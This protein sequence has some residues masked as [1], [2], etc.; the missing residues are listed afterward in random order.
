MTSMFSALGPTKMIPSCFNL[1]SE[2]QR[3]THDA[4][5]STIEAVE[6]L[7]APAISGAEVF[8]HAQEQL[9]HLGLLESHRSHLGHG[10][11]LGH[12]EAPFLTAE[13]SD[14]INEGDVVAVEVALYPAADTAMRLEHNY[15]IT[16]KGNER[17]SQHSLVLEQP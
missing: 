5:R 17:L 15:L 9:S 13:S 3:R 1:R 10:L 8:R 4:A 16:A 7:L 11:G 14:T 12:P 2:L 6:A